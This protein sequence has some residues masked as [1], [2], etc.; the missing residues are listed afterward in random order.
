MIGTNHDLAAIK[1]I[2]NREI[3]RLLY[4]A[5]GTR[6]TA[7]IERELSLRYRQRLAIC[8]VLVN[9]R[10]EASNKIVDFS[11]WFSGNGALDRV[12]MVSCSGAGSR[13][14]NGSTGRDDKAE[15]DS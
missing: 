12:L 1:Q 9:R 13:R 14:E 11:R 15:A 7:C 5:G 2:A 6:D 10:I 3:D 4:L 8:A